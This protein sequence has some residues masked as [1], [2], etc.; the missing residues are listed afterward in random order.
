MDLLSQDRPRFQQIKQ[1]SGD[2]GIL[3]GNFEFGLELSNGVD[4]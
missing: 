4:K 2:S 3:I 1:D